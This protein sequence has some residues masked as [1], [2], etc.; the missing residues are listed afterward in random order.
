MLFT[1]PKIA[2]FTPMPRPSVS[3]TA[4]ENPGLR[5]IVCSAYRTSAPA[6]WNHRAPRSSRIVSRC[7]SRPPNVRSAR[8][9]ASGAGTPPSINLRVSMSMW[10]ANSSSMRASARRPRTTSR[11]RARSP[12]MTLMA[13]LLEHELNRRHEPLPL[14]HFEPQPLLPVLC[15]AVVTRA[16]VVVGRLPRAFDVAAM[17]EALQG[18]VER[19]LIHVEAAL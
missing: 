4:T 2:P 10:K 11:R 1:Y 19:A 17:L 13:L 5:F 3:A 14:F 7:P 12:L 16:P 6:S 18:G 8:L 9:R 15:D